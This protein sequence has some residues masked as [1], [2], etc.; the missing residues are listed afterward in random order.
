MGN[1]HMLDC[2]L[3]DG[4]WV[5]QFCFGTEVMQEILAAAENAGMEY[6]ELGY[7]DSGKGSAA[8][9]SEYLDIESISRNH[10]LKSKKP[11]TQYMVMI[12]YGKY[13]MH[14]LPARS[15]AGID[16]IRL[17]FHR[18]DMAGAVCIGREILEKGYL[19]M[20]Q[21][22]ACCKYTDDDFRRLLA[23]IEKDLKGLKAFYI[24]DSFGSMKPADVRRR[25]G[26]A[27]SILSGQT[28]LGLHSHNN[29]Q[30]S[31]QNAVEAVNMGLQRDLIIDA[32]LSGVGKGA[33]NLRIEA[34][35]EYLN[36]ACSKKYN[37][38][39]LKEAS[40][41]MRSSLQ[42]DNMWGYRME[43]C[44]AA[45]HELTPSYADMFCREQGLGMEEIDEL[46]GLIPDEKKD[47]FD[48]GTAKK[49]LKS[50]ME[51]RERKW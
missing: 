13:P 14:L 38:A 35:A 41:R 28:C 32:T 8:G 43:Y 2:T 7:L 18:K 48:K 47:S 39:V 10:L 45:K 27:D 24:V 49:V 16:G 42:P 23:G 26:M 17:C 37:I 50:Y 4:G 9:R 34:F 19:L 22:M 30:L 21:P 25:L 20:L 33:G 44:L 51:E 12:D 1:V 29:M 46:L 6:V 36:Q 11:Y 5:N 40:E 15:R 3:R 31:F